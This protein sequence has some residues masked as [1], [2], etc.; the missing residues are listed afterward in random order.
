MDAQEI[1]G[2]EEESSQL[3]NIRLCI[4]LQIFTIPSDCKTLDMP[5]LLIKAARK[6]FYLIYKDS[7]QP[8]LADN[9]LNQLDSHSLSI[10]L[11]ATVGHQN[12]WDTAPLT[13]EWEGNQESLVSPYILFCSIPAY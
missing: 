10:T 2:M 4:A 1:Y 5:T 13:R 12:K 9:I 6:A 3:G 11:L 7:E 8:N